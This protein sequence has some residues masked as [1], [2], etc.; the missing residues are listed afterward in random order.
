[1]DNFYIGEWDIERYNGDMSQYQALIILVDLQ[2]DVLGDISF[3]AAN[4]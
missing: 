3:I 2:N 1:M 4:I